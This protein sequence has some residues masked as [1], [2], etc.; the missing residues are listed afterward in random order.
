MLGALNN[1]MLKILSLLKKGELL[2]SRS[3]GDDDIRDLECIYQKILPYLQTPDAIYAI[4][5]S[6]AIACLPTFSAGMMANAYF[7]SHEVWGGKYFR[8]ENRSPE[9][10]DRWQAALNI[11]SKTGWDGKVVVDLACG[12]G[13]LYASLG[14]SPELLIG[15]DISWGALKSARD[16]G[17][18]PILADAQSVPLKSEIADV[19]VA[20]AVLHHCDSPELVLAEAARLVKPG[21]L[22]ITDMDPQKGA[23]DFKG[24]GLALYRNRFPIYWLMRSPAYKCP[25][26]RAGRLLTEIHNRQPGMGIDPA[27][28]E[29]V[30]APLKF[31]ARVYP[32]NHFIGAEALAG[33]LGT[34]PFKWRLGQW[35]S[36]IDSRS[37]EAGL[38]LMCVAHRQP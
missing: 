23:W 18:L 33:Q 35:L 17:Y 31:E 26:E 15:V 7:F 5:D 9:F 14:G 29:Q 28:F 12:P 20:N 2:D 4:Q 8:T 38:S 13:N 36:G 27:L 37:A 22:L 1:A 34:A 6:I 19:V 25:A 32:H 21:G 3:M 10:C 11:W 24:L 30:L 16:L